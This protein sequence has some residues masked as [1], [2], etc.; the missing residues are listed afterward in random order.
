[1][2]SDTNGEIQFILALNRSLPSRAEMLPI[3]RMNRCKPVV[4]PELLRRLTG[5]A[6]PVG[7]VEQLTLTVGAPE[8]ATHKL[9]QRRIGR[10]G[11]VVCNLRL[12]IIGYVLN[13]TVE[14]GQPATAVILAVK[15]AF[16]PNK[17][18]VGPDD[19]K[20]ARGQLVRMCQLYNFF[21]R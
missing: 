8:L 10:G 1:M 15:S 20:A 11:A 2:P 7:I 17:M 14:D 9:T 19:A 5:E 6:H 3:V 16:E 21:V 4:I 12:V 18:P 13:D